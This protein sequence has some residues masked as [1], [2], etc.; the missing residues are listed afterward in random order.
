M[1]KKS[2]NKVDKKG[3]K[4]TWEWEET[5]ETIKA[6]EKLHETIRKLESDSP[7]YGVGK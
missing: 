1:T 6:L 5:P 2:N 3:R 4:E 7:D